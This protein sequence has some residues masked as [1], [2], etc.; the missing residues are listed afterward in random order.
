MATH[1]AEQW[2]LAYAVPFSC[3][4]IFSN[5][6]TT[7]NSLSYVA[8]NY[9]IVR[10]HCRCPYLVSCRFSVTLTWVP[11][12][13]NIPGNCNTDELARTGAGNGSNLAQ[14]ET[15]TYPISM[16]SPS[17]LLDSIGP[18]RTWTEGAPSSY[19][20]LVATSSRSQWPWCTGNSVWGRI[21]LP[22]NDFCHGC[23]SAGE[24]TTVIYCI[25]LAKCRYRLL[26][27]STLVSLIELS[28]TD[29]KDIASFIKLSGWLTNVG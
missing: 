12:Q 16:R 28:S 6:Q 24:E 20:D 3:I 17:P 21:W 15:L 13:C 2:I 25:S 9:K 1:R 14:T 26:G 29:V 5:S 4:S 22:F 19:F 8:N 10:K 27:S 7:I 11:V 23:R 18:R